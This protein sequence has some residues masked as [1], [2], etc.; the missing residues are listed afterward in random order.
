MLLSEPQ[1]VLS[2]NGELLV[3]Q[4]SK[5]K[6]VEGAADRTV[7]LCVRRMAFDR[8][9][10]LFVQMS[11]GAFSMRAK[12]SE[13][14]IVCCDC[15][16]HSETG[17]VLP[18][19]L[20]KVKKQNGVF[21]Q[22]LLLLHSSDRFEQCCH[23]KLDYELK[24]DV[25][26][27][28][29]PSVLWRHADKL[30][31]I[32]SGT[33]KV[34]SAPVQLSSVVWTGEIE[35][36]GTVVLG[37]RAACLPESEDGDEF[38][39]SDRAIWGSEF[40]GYAIEMQ[41]MLTGTCFMPHA[42][43]R[44]VSSVCVCKNERLKK[45]LRISAV[46]ITHKNQLIWFQ[47][48]V[49]KGVCELPYE[50]PCLIKT[51]VTS[52]N[53]LLFIV[54]FS[55]GNIC[56]VRRENLQV[57][58]K[59]QKVKSVLVDD[60][61]G[62][63]TEQLLLLFNDD[64]NTDVLNMFKIMDFGKI[65]YESGI[66]YKDDVPAAEGLKENGLLTIQALETRLQAGLTSVRELQQHLGLKKRVILESCR[67]LIDL[68]EG[69]SHILP[70]AKKEGLVSLWDDVEKPYSVS[71]EPSLTPKLQ[72]HF[73]EKL[74]QRVVGDN[75]V[76]GVKLTE[77]FC[78]S[79]CDISL[80]LVMD[81]DFSL[82]SPIIECRN[83]IIKVNE[84]FSAL[85]VSSCQIEPPQKKMKLDLRSKNDLK[86]E[87]HKRCSKTQLDK[88]NTVTAVT[89]LSPLLAFH[90]V[91]CAVLLH[92]KKQKHRNDDFRKSK[93]ITLF[94]GKI[95]LNLEDISNEKYSVNMLKDNSYCTGSVEDIVAILAV[96]IR[97][98]FQIVSSD[99]TLT[100]V[101]SWL[102]GEMDCVPFKECHD[103]VF[104][105]KAGNIYGTVFSWTLKNPF[106]GVL[107]LF[108]RSLT[109]LFQCLHSLTR[110]L[111]PSCDVKLLKSGSKGLLTE[112]LALALEKEMF[113]SRS[114]L[115]S[116]ENKAENNLT[117][118]NEPGRKISDPPVA[119]LLDSEDG[120]QHFRE[121]LQNERE[122]CVLS[123]NEMMDGT[124]YQK[125]ALKVA[126]AQLRSDMIVWRL[127]KS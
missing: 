15:A 10:Q 18:C 87:F 6:H 72:D 48:G 56:V 28:A 98:S 25:R 27:F 118:W 37:I 90:R 110:V 33:C 31:Y 61:I 70:S 93:R 81:H 8:D 73:I 80:S 127:S 39:T 117:R 100:R 112:Q 38:S 96:S 124:L 104:S 89:N 5:T 32:S 64:S 84:I 2:Y 114:F 30:F 77:S 76:V 43:S 46:A 102:L 105:H 51:A 16:T 59:W 45:Q 29:G 71:K 4:L 120:V 22:L 95:L 103:M 23:F 44:V 34:L 97:F 19:V 94:C 113:T 69:R 63:G 7:K 60:F 62:S 92:A 3:F 50:K 24:E 47:D 116:K 67:A 106:E 125:M 109:V 66:N 85:S 13:T 26:L 122:Q 35:G 53:D 36:E 68:V 88:T 49:P 9:T 40:F 108:C 111:P 52:S 54:S 126:E 101:N 75:L 55:S 12:H 17:I 58:S 107:T 115:F 1:H 41:K 14:E 119:S 78:L 99:C 74:W 20:M 123:M 21:E 57:T 65:N 82:M 11:S 83:K 79:V 86:K 121:K 42:Y 91:C